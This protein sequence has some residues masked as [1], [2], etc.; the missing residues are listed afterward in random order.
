MR[1]LGLYTFFLF[2]LVQCKMKPA[3]NNVKVKSFYHDL[4]KRDTQETETDESR[5]IHSYTNGIQFSAYSPSSF[6]Y[7]PPTKTARPEQKKFL[8]SMDYQGNS[9]FMTEGELNNLLKSPLARK[10]GKFFPQFGWLP[11][12]R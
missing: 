5:G 9:Q 6:D 10:V 1:K 7:S 8:Y 2:C 3:S 4:A 11:I 12:D